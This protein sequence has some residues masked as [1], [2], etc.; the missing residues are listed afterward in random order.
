MML[1]LLTFSIEGVN[2]A[3]QIEDSKEQAN[4]TFLRS[5]RFFLMLRGLS[6][7]N[8]KHVSDKEGLEFRLHQ[9]VNP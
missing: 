8:N 1:P 2:P 6:N 4:P 3:K 5:S 9:P 7:I